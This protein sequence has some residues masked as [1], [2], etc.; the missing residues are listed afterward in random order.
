ML[1]Y[2]QILCHFLGDYI[3]Q[4]D[5]MASKKTTDIKV[6][7]VHGIMYTLPF[8]FISTSI[9]ALTVICITHTIIDRYRLA[10]Y[11][12]WAKNFLAPKSE[13]TKPFSECQ[14]TG[15]SADKP[16]FIAVW[17]L[18]ITDNIMHVIINNLALRY[19]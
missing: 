14:A 12:V 13:W 16:A 3:L 8:L 6:A 2:N 4:S 7:L 5:W 1:V 10:R 11:I 9:I 19:L 15:S 17:L 18:I